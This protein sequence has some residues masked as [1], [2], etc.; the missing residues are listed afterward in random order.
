MNG[1][2][3]YSDELLSA[4]IDGELSDEERR[5]V[6][7][8]LEQ[9]AE[10]RRQLKT[11]R[12]LSAL[13][14]DLRHFAMPPPTAERIY[15]ILDKR[16]QLKSPDQASLRAAVSEMLPTTSVP[17]MAPVTF[18]SRP[19]SAVTEVASSMVPVSSTS[20]PASMLRA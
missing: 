7:Q 15:A 10:Y 17:P 4:Y 19:A 1:R 3:A 2:D 13:L 11:L 9:D 6:E 12:S 18:T 16:V 8:R 20:R 5:H 14:N